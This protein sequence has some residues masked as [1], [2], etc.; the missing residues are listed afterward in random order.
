M[1]CYCWRLIAPLEL[2]CASV[3]QYY[4]SFKLSGKVVKVLAMIRDLMRRVCVTVTE[5]Q[6]WNVAKLFQENVAWLALKRNKGCWLNAR[7]TKR[8]RMVGEVGW[9]I[10][11]CRFILT[12]PVQVDAESSLSLARHLVRIGEKVVIAELGD[13]DMHEEHKQYIFR[14]ITK[15]FDKP[16]SLAISTISQKHLYQRF[17]KVN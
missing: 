6:T 3:S 16:E 14:A 12:M 7:R 8:M 11:E 15:T 2:Y 13:W 4:L 5:I 1:L 17:I 9:S 10:G